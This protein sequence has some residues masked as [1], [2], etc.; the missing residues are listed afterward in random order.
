MGRIM[1]FKNYL[2]AY[3]DPEAFRS[4]PTPISEPYLTCSIKVKAFRQNM[5]F[6]MKRYTKGTYSDG[7]TMFY[8]L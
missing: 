8:S 6:F 3:N 5:A 7:S 1:F 4:G 2:K